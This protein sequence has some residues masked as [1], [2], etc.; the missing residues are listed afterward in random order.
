M[1]G[2]RKRPYHI[3]DRLGYG[4]A[5]AHPLGEI[6]QFRSCRKFLKEKE[7]AHFLIV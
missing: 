7:V 3:E 1:G 5:P 4:A 2:W 6:F